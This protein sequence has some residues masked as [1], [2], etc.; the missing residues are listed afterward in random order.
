MSANRPFHHDDRE[1][2]DLLIDEN[3]LLEIGLT[4]VTPGEREPRTVRFKYNPDLVDRLLAEAGYEPTHIPKALRRAALDVAWCREKGRVG[5]E[6]IAVIT[7]RS[8]EVV[9]T[10][11]AALNAAG[12]PAKGE[13]S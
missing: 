9:R 4:I 1:T 3:E 8:Q 2:E 5:D 11:L 7:G 6:D 10:A 12:V 13:S